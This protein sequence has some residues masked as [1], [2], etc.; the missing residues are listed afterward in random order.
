MKI[1]NQHY[2]KVYSERRRL[3]IPCVYRPFFINKILDQHGSITNH[4]LIGK[5]IQKE[6]SKKEYIIQSVQFHWYEGYYWNFVAI[7]DRGSSIVRTFE[8]FNSQSKIITTEIVKFKK[9]FLF[10]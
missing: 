1:N 8:N 7:D 9:Q 2:S 5:K 10:L 4:P 3:E 6:S